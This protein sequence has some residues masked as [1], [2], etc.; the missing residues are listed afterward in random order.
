MWISIFI[1]FSLIIG[2]AFYSLVYSDSH[3]N[4][5][6]AVQPI[7]VSEPAF[8]PE[9]NLMVSEDILSSAKGGPCVIP[10][11]FRVNLYR[12][13]NG[14]SLWN[15]SKDKGPDFFWTLLSVNRLD[16]AH[17]ISI[18]QEI[19]I[20]N[21]CGILHTVKDSETLEDIA[22][23][24]GVGIR[25]IIRV[26]RI[27]NPNEIKQ[28]IDM[29]VP[30]ARV[31]QAL[32][33]ELMQKSGIPPK[34]AWPC[35]RTARISSGFGYR[36]DPF[37]GRRAFHAGLDL[38]PGYGARVEASMDGIVTFAGRMGGYGKLIVIRHREGFQTRYGHLS[39]IRSGIRRGKFVR[40]GQRIG[41]VGSTGR[42]TGPHLH[43]EIRK[44]GRPQNPLKYIGR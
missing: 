32:S 12:A 5:G 41:S 38:A 43:F 23:Q 20:P 9:E 27:L 15:L 22:L 25:N 44:S 40:Q 10:P 17:E 42:S 29:F 3:A 8:L 2:V 11:L 24:Y 14:D 28:G 7:Q 4:E 13:K 31:S 39:Q 34:F 6:G 36:K 19:K 30:G 33:K 37:S 18:G 21:Q 16:K 26:N 1:E 35:R